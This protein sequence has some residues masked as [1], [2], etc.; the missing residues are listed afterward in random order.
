MKRNNDTLPIYMKVLFVA[1]ILMIVLLSL[2]TLVYSI[3]LAY[4]LATGVEMSGSGGFGAVAVT[5][6]GILIAGVFF[7]MTFRIDRAAALEARR[8]AKEEV[9]KLES[10]VDNMQNKELETLRAR[11]NESEWDW[12]AFKSS[13]TASSIVEEMAEKKGRPRK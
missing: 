13:D 8:A 2:S 7:F 11:I 5:S 10:R 12:A 1:V 4:G 3:V 6:L 9:Q